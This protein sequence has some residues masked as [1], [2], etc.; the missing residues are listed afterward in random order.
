MRARAALAGAIGLVVACWPAIARAAPFDLAWSAPEGC[1][2]RDEIVQATRARLGEQ[3]SEAR[4]EL[5]VHGEVVAQDT[6]GFVVRLSMTDASGH[7][8]GEREVRVEQGSCSEVEAPTSLVLAM[9][10]A[11]ARPLRELPA[12]DEPHAEPTEPPPVA[13]KPPVTRLP[14][15][16]AAAEAPRHRLLLGAA[17]V[18]S[19]GIL[20]TVALGF[21][22]RA[23]YA[24]GFGLLFGLEIAAEASRAVHVAGG[25]IGFQLF[26]AS[27]RV[28]LSILRTAGLELIPTVGA[29]G[30]LL[31]TTPTGF[32]AVHNE[33]RSTMLAGAGALVRAKI[34]PAVFVEAL[35]ELEAVLLR[36]RFRIREEN[37]LYHI[38][39][40]SVFEGRV[41]VG[42]AYEFR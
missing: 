30:A 39:R 13:S 25:E 32:T 22:V 5:F 28:G 6:G 40:A 8:L 9:M 29:R 38:H 31:R 17:G 16:P 11:V 4:P 42:I 35:P 1:P 20:P 19:T 24:P 7:A 12:Y 10:I 18:A 26:S 3:P 2:S 41:S 33:I 14:P 27:A 23:A 37:K 34:A 36:D 21:G 15:P